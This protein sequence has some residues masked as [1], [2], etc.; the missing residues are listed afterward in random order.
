MKVYTHGSHINFQQSARE[1]Q[2]KDMVGILHPYLSQEAGCLFG[3]IM[4]ENEEIYLFGELDEMSVDLQSEK[5][6]ISYRQ[7]DTE[8][9]TYIQYPFERFVLSQEAV[10]DVIEG[11]QQVSYS[12]LFLTFTDEFAKEKNFFLAPQGVVSEP[13]A[14]VAEFWSVSSE[15]GRDMD[16]AISGCSASDLNQQLRAQRKD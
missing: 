1:I 16:F 14:Y 7:A 6:N 3:N 15:V 10:F 13:L 5:W 8:Q 12:V 4:L 9:I 11:E 2:L